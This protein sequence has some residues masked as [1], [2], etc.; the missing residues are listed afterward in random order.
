MKE[1]RMYGEVQ[2]LLNQQMYNSANYELA[3]CDDEAA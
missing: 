3:F 2:D 1:K